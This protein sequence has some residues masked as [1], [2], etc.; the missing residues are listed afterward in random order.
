MASPEESSGLLGLGIQPEKCSVSHCDL[1][2]VLL[3]S[4]GRPLLC[5]GL[6]HRCLSGLVN[7]SPHKLLRE[8]RAVADPPHL[9]SRGAW[10]CFLLA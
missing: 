5:V 9:H 1:K 8:L 6:G 2:M 3:G 4:C 7:S 10:G